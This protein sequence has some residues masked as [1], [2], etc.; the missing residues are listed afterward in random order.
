MGSEGSGACLPAHVRDEHALGQVALQQR[1]ERVAVLPLLAPPLLLRALL[2]LA[3]A[4]LQVPA[5]QNRRRSDIRDAHGQA[6]RPAVTTSINS[7]LQQQR[8][9]PPGSAES[10]LLQLTGS[11]CAEHPSCHHHPASGTLCQGHEG[12]AACTAFLS[13]VSA[14][15]HQEGALPGARGKLL[16]AQFSS[17]LFQQ[18]RPQ[19]GRT[20]C[21]PGRPPGGPACRAP[22]TRPRPPAAARPCAT[23]CPPA[24][25]HACRAFSMSHPGHSSAPFVH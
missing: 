22:R 1:L 25:M 15:G 3:L 24:H 10:S 11:A 8:A 7:M 13:S 23:A 2:I 4:L 20:G 21:T 14:R 16:H 6:A 12:Q 18:G 5:R 9:W 19:R 17:V